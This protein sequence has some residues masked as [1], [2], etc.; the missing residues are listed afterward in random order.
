[1]PPRQ[2]AQLAD[3]LRRLLDDPALGS[4]LA[5]SASARIAA[6]Y[7]PE[8]YHRKLLELYRDLMIAAVD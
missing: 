4:R 6:C 5:A 8:V 7:T 3:A 2:P 1:V